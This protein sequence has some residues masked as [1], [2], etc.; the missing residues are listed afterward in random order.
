M[1]CIEKFTFARTFADPFGDTPRNEAPPPP[2]APTVVFSED[3]LAAARAE[4]RAE[5]VAEGRE[6][7]LAE[8]RAGLEERQA[9]TLERLAER[10]DQAIAEREAIERAAERGAFALAAAAL[11]KALPALHRDFAT[12][13]I[14]AM[15]VELSARMI[16]APTLTIAVHP[17][18]VAA[19]GQRLSALAPARGQNAR[20]T[21]AAEPGLA[22]G[23]CTI[24]WSGG[25][26]E[27]RLAALLSGIDDVIATLTGADPRPVDANGSGSMQHNG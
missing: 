23:D 5:G 27:R 1:T 9:D 22:E 6:E 2:P 26:A 13:E 12:I 14:E 18:V 25:G 19:L 16:N 7:G 15:V 17:A 24:A 10:I 4:A 8:A 20:L 11:R 3:D 21:V